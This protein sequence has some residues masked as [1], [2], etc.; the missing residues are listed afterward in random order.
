VAKVQLN[1]RFCVAL[2]TSVNPAAVQ[3]NTSSH[4]L[5]NN[6]TVTISHNG[7]CGPLVLQYLSTVAATAKSQPFG[8]STTV[9]IDKN[10]PSDW[11]SPP[12]GGRNVDLELRQ[13][14]DGKILH[15]AILRTIPK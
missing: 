2:I 10:N 12:T 15:V 5:D 13:G 8:S 7:A 1:V 4:K 6:V 9:T 11:D 14:I 3:V